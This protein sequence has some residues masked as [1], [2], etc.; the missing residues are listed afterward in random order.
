MS[1]DPGGVD[2]SD[3]KLSTAYWISACFLRPP[4]GSIN[5]APLI[6]PLDDGKRPP[7]LLMSSVGKPTFPIL[8]PFHQ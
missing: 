4:I 5:Q 1:L 6:A 8:F 7:P 3:T 2:E